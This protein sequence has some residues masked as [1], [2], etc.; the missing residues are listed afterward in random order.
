[1]KNNYSK[2]L[3]Y[4]IRYSELLKSGLRRITYINTGMTAKQVCDV[5]DSNK[6]K[7]EGVTQTV[8]T[9]RYY[10]GMVTRDYIRV[11]VS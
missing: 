1:M 11:Y 8:R 6:L 3:G 7:Y 9:S 4:S 2:A 5:L 10:G